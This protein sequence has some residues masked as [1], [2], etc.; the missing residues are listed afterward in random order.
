M[1]KSPGPVIFGEMQPRD[2]I[3]EPIKTLSICTLFLMFETIIL[4]GPGTE[5]FPIV[6][7]R[8][9]KLC[10]PIVNKPMVLYTMELLEGVSSKFFMVGLNEEKDHFMRAIGGDIRVPVEYVGIETYDGTVSSL[11]SVY[12]RIIKSDVI[13][14]KGDIITNMNISSMISKYLSSEKIF[15]TVIGNATSEAPIIGYKEENLV[16][17]A[18]SSED[19]VPFQLLKNSG[20][21]ILTKEL[22]IVQL[23]VFKTSL[24]GMFKSEHFS[25]KYGL[26]PSL[27]RSLISINPVGI[28]R[29]EKSYIHQVR[30]ID[31]YLRANMLLKRHIND[32][33]TETRRMSESHAKFVKRYVAEHNLKDFKNVVGN[34]TRLS[35]VLLLNSILGH[36]CDVGEDTRIISSLIMDRVI[37]GSNSHIEGCLIGPGVSII[38]GSS[39]VNCKVSPGYIFSDAVDAE[40]QIFS[41]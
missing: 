34:N 3:P 17:Y 26:L 33:S 39:L 16:F 28:Y 32:R 19:D 6:N 2:T 27:V 13:V 21:L 40:S 31:G 30:D 25:F 7:D 10:L 11:L 23:Y 4:I 22:D 8:L 18:N 24:F 36:E 38:G 37:I 35:D 5:L 14:C 41:L 9:P 29:P 20:S 15:M 12:P 1:D